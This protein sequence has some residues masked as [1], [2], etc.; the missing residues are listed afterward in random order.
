M[1]SDPG[2]PVDS[3]LPQSNTDG[4]RFLPSSAG[5]EITLLAHDPSS[6]IEDF[7][8]VTLTNIKPLYSPKSAAGTWHCSSPVALATASMSA[9]YIHPERNQ[10]D[11][12]SDL[13]VLPTNALQSYIYWMCLYQV[14]QVLWKGSPLIYLAFLYLHIRLKLHW[15]GDEGAFPSR[16]ERRNLGCFLP[17]LAGVQRPC[18]QL[19][20]T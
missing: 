11:E 10:M 5:Q 8:I 9:P 19:N 3:K 17:L 15:N 7:I 2:F 6:F 12:L 14:A 18:R 1:G 13:A 4:Q 16:G 20:P